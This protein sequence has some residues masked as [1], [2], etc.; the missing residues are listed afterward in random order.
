MPEILS[1]V[2]NN[3]LT[4]APAVALQ[5]LIMLTYILAG[6]IYVLINFTS[7]LAWIFIALAM[8]ALIVMRYTKKDHHRPY[9]VI[10]Y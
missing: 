4:P 5:G 2:H 6:N 8:V 10:N 7:F 3:R 9:K 1:Y